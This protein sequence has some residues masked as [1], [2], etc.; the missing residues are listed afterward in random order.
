MVWLVESSVFKWFILIVVITN[1]IT[2]AMQDFSYRIDSSVPEETP[3]GDIADKV[4]VTIFCIEC[5]LKVIAM[6]FILDQN[7]YLR[8]AWNVLDFL[9]LITGVLE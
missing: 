4:F 5:V 9:C 7:S 8:S 2:M 1:S 6:G 3:F